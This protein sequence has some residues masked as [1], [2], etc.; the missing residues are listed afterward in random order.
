MTK[1]CQTILKPEP[2]ARPIPSPKLKKVA[3]FLKNL[4]PFSFFINYK[5]IPF[6][7]LHTLIWN[8]SYKN[9]I[10]TPSNLNPFHPSPSPLKIYKYQFPLSFS[11][12]QPISHLSLK[13]S[14]TLN[15]SLKTLKLSWFIIFVASINFIQEFQVRWW[16]I[17]LFGGVQSHSSEDSSSLKLQASPIFQILHHFNTCQLN[18]F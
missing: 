4:L 12:H 8:S 2:E 14:Q 18:S 7:P 1:L 5:I 6:W 11:P 13:L 15:S 9:Y 16:R 10:L 3:I 17:N